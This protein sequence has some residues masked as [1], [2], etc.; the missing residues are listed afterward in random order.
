MTALQTRLTCT[1]LPWRP[2]G[3]SSTRRFVNELVLGE[4]SDLRPD[5]TGYTSHFELYLEAMEDVGA[6]LGPITSFLDAISAPM[7]VDDALT[8]CSVPMAASRF[9]MSTWG[10]VETG[11][12][13]EI[14]GSF[15]FGRESLIPEMFS[16]IRR[17]AVTVPGLAKMRDYLDRHIELDGDEH[18]PLAFRMVVDV[19]GDDRERWLALVCAAKRAVQ[20]RNELWDGV[21]HQLKNDPTCR[22]MSEVVI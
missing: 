18:S 4:E 11:S 21:L 16:S 13:P 3:S 2:V 10:I 12:L 14:V 22:R 5:A 7:S 20:A 8:T 6:D 19:C 9:V 15:A 17:L 1:S